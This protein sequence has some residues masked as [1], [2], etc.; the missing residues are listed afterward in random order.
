MTINTTIDFATILEVS[1]TL[2]GCIQLSELL[3]QVTQIILQ[4]SGG[5]RCALILPNQYGKWYLKAIAT[6]ETTQLSSEL[7]DGNPNLPI[8][9]IKYVRKTQKVL[10]I[11]HSQTDLPFTDEYINQQQP[12]SALCLPLVIQGHLIGIIYLQSSINDLFVGDR[13]LVIK[14]L[15]T[16]AAISLKNTQ[17][18][19]E[20][21][22]AE[23]T[24]EQNNAFL[25]AQLE[26]CVDG[27]LVTNGNRQLHTYNQKFASI[28]KI[29]KTILE[30]KDE[31]QLLGFLL[32]QL[33][34]PSN[35]LGKVE[36]LYVHPEETSYDEIIL[37]DK[38]ILKRVSTPVKL[39]SEV[40]YGRIWYFRDITERK[41][42]EEASHL[43][44]SVVES[45]DDAIITKTLDGI[46]TSWNRAAMNLF[47]YSPTEVI[48]KPISILFP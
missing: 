23:I 30:T 9:L 46:I 37:K 31:R 18:L 5:D 40:C 28:W 35:F 2:F 20:S 22:E 19:H 45:T 14:F 32:E 47:G 41:K 12:K 8:K 11:N 17:L 13:L 4:H 15:C 44:F 29:P 34:N 26:S 6:P 43:L 16:Q 10:F 3:Y 48:G 33:E 25:E 42:A 21:Q 39:P 1:Q 36:Y 24:L 27:I 38:R 7:L